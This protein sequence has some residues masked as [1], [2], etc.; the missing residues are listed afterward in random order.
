MLNQIPQFIYGTAWKKDSTT[1]LVKKAINNGFRAIDTA[2]QA[3]HYS[4]ALVGEALKEVLNSNQLQRSDLFLQSK[5]TSIDGQ[6]DRLPYDQDADLKTQIEQSFTSSLKHLNTDYLDSYLLHGPLNYPLLGKEELLIWQKF[7]EL[8]ESNKVK[9]IGISN[10]NIHQLKILLENC[11]I[12]PH[13]LQNRCFAQTKWDQDIRHICND[14]NIKYQGFSLLTANLNFIQNSK[15]QDIAD[16]YQISLAEVIFRFA[17]QIG[18]IPLTGTTDQTHMQNDL[19]IFNF[20]L[21]KDE[22]NIIE[23]IASI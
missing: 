15:I 14:N 10:F 23:S 6:D 3:K 12:K 9:A 13:F 20:K 1:E 5:F 22:I 16:K 17:F 21:T 8:Y 11:K 7:E 4:E 19:N 18:M 2:N